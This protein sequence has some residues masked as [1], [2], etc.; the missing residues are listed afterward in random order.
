MFSSIAYAMAP[1]AQSGGAEGGA[2]AMMS[3]MMPIIL[4]IGVFYF[5]LIRPQQKKQKEHLAMQNALKKGDPIVTSGGLYGRIVE[6]DAEKAVVDLG[7][8]KVVVMRQAINLLADASKSPIPAGKKEKP[9]KKKDKEQPAV[10]EAE[11][12]AESNESEK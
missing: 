2:G 3:S 6:I 7:E 11:A 5:L 12:P 1:A 8:N 4:I 10:E 9:S